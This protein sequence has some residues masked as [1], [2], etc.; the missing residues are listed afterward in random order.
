MNG[1]A[2]SFVSVCLVWC[3][4]CA[5]SVAYAEPVNPATVFDSS[6]FHEAQVL[7]AI[8]GQPEEAIDFAKANLAINKLVDPNIDVNVNLKKIEAIVTTIQALLPVGASSKDKM[9]AVRKYLYEA[10]AWNGHQ[11]YRY[12]FDDPKDTKIGN[13]LLPTY[14][15]TKK[16]NCISMP[17]LFIALG[18]QL[19]INVTASTAPLHVLVKYTDSDTGQSYNLEA[20]SGANPSRDVWYQ[21]TM[22]ITDRT[23]ANRIYL[24]KLTK[25]ETVA[26]MA[27]VLAENYL[28]KQQYEK[29]MMIADVVLK[30]YPN[31]VE[32]MVM[33]GTLFYHLLAKHYLSKYPA[34][35]LIPMGERPYFEFLDINNR[36]WFDKAEALGWHEPSKEDEQNYLDTVRQDAGKLKTEQKR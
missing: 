11:V 10:G 22:H 32:A 23:L 18:Q 4:F 30:Y 24:Q 21:Q 31:A 14:L 9:L 34:P 12:D 5:G 36:Y 33:K 8:L 17:L 15:A 27:M 29:A 35:Y 1:V 13:K 19:G 6:N 28:A 25:R 2:S 16:G 26:V 3:C 7:K 20:T